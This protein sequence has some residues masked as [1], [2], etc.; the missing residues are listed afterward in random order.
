MPST[1][2]CPRGRGRGKWEHSGLAL[3]SSCAPQKQG[4]D[5]GFLLLLTLPVNFLF[6]G[7]PF[8]AMAHTWTSPRSSFVS[9][10][11]LTSRLFL[12]KQSP[13]SSTLTLSELLMSLN[14]IFPPR[15]GRCGWLANSRKLIPI[16]GAANTSLPLRSAEPEGDC[17]SLCACLPPTPMANELQWL[18]YWASDWVDLGGEENKINS[19]EKE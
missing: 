15:A 2:F 8:K 18:H 7:R 17:T 11:L 5:L 19:K 12:S 16:G 6:A 9:R 4:K 3:D 10:P 1:T 13:G 14:P